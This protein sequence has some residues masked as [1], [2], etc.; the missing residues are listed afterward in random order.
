MQVPFVKYIRVPK[1]HNIIFFF[2][3]SYKCGDS[4]KDI[5]YTTQA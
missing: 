3:N 2:R 5:Q 4:D 1:I